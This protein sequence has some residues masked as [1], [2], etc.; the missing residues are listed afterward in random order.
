MLMHVV[1]VTAS[2]LR[3]AARR[4]ASTL[5]LVLSAAVVAGV[6]TCMASLARGLHQQF[7]SAGAPHRALVL[8]EAAAVVVEGALSTEQVEF[9]HQVAEGAGIDRIVNAT[10]R[11]VGKNGGPPESVRV[12]GITPQG[13]RMHPNIRIVQGRMFEAGRHEVGAG[14]N[15]TAVFRGTDIGDRL[16]LAI[17]EFKIVGT[18][19]SGDHLDSR[20]LT[21]ADTAFGNWCNAVVVDLPSA[22]AF[23]AFR[24]ALNAHTTLD[25]GVR[26][27]SEYYEELGHLRSE[28][29]REIG[30]LLGATMAVG[31]IFC[32]ANVMLSTVASRRSEIA[33]LRAIGFPSATIAAS[34]LL[35]TLAMVV[36]G[37]ASGAAVSWALLD[38][39]L[40]RE[41]GS[42][43]T[44]FNPVFDA[45]T[46][47]HGLLWVVAVMAAGGAFATRRTLARPIGNDLASLD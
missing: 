35:E 20:F 31:G 38:G 17:G 14:V 3:A 26:R 18:F 36:V 27:E 37:A 33:T 21:D 12:Q 32:S 19:E 10:A 16:T 34:V 4:P 44:T 7:A 29:L 2:N 22:G 13:V 5:A 15:A 6:T 28:A 45:W 43:S 24:A 30:L 47:G 1:L 40:V 46:L 11:L 42:S 25:F 41:G 9:I 23:D 39:A 8:Q